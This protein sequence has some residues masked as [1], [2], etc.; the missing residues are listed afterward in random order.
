LRAAITT[1]RRML[2]ESLTETKQTALGTLERY[3]R[4]YVEQ[5]RQGTNRRRGVLPANRV[6]V[7]AEIEKFVV[8]LSAAVK[9]CSCSNPGVS[10]QAMCVIA[11]MPN[12]T[13][14]PLVEYGASKWLHPVDP[15]TRRLSA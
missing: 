6:S 15:V 7:S 9:A 10:R 12:V 8:S 5:Y 2:D 4:R 3:A 11:K 13:E 14:D 1:A